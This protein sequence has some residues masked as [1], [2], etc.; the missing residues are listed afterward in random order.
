LHN[1]EPKKKKRERERERELKIESAMKAVEARRAIDFLSI[2]HNLKATKRTGWIRKGVSGPESIADH[3]YR[4]SVMAMIA[5]DEGVDRNKCIKLAIVHDIAEALAGDIA[6]SDGIP[7]EEKHRLE[8]NA[9]TT[10][11]NAIGHDEAVAE[12]IK[13]LWNEYEDGET[14]E[15]KLLKDIDKLEMILQALEYEER[16]KHLD[17]SE[18][19]TSVQGKMKTGTGEQWAQ[20][21]VRRRRAKKE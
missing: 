17:L 4:M 13:E 21:I 19:F 8:V 1:D 18:F 20:E 15:A 14:N 12:E 2:L 9:L 11:C 3:M 10:M 7:K 16:E 5:G 6:P